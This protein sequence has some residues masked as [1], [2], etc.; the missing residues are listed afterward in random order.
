MLLL[1]LLF[2]PLIR[3]LLRRLRV[4]LFLLPLKSLALLLLLCAE[5]ILILLVLLPQLRLTA[6]LYSRSGCSRNFVRMQGRARHRPIA[7]CQLLKYGG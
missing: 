5:L 7:S 1:Q 2:F 3:L 6:R 4:F